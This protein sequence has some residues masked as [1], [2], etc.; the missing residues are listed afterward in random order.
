[1]KY[2]LYTSPVQQPK[3]IQKILELKPGTSF[4]EE[5]GL[6][7]VHGGQTPNVGWVFHDPEHK[8]EHS[9]FFAI[10]RDKD[11][12][13]LTISFK[14]ERLW[15][16]ALRAPSH[17]PDMT[18]VVFSRFGHD[19]VETPEGY[20]SDGGQYCAGARSGWPSGKLLPEYCEFNMHTREIKGKNAY[21]ERP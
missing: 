5:I 18:Y 10:Y 4:V 15:V 11:D 19:Y 13:W 1:V 7:L 21:V 12:R 3:I 17:D 8:P 20:M 14:E 2:L 16:H 9:P 6:P